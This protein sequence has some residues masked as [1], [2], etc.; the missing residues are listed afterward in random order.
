MKHLSLPKFRFT[1]HLLIVLGVCLVAGVVL[2]GAAEAYHEKQVADNQARHDAQVQA[3]KDKQ[4]QATIDGLR[5]ENTQL[6]AAHTALCSY[7]NSLV[8]APKTKGYVTVPT[9]A[10]CPNPK[11]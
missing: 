10:A 11:Q 8:M 6:G 9:A 7:V 2:I 5:N 1:K 3:A 4:T